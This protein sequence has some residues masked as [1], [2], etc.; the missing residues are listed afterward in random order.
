MVHNIQT[1]VK[2]TNRLLRK[3]SLHTILEQLDGY[4]MEL[5]NNERRNKYH[6]MKQDPY[7]FIVEVLIFFIMM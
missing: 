4:V 5:S 7:S 2:E 6:K 3:Q 1:K